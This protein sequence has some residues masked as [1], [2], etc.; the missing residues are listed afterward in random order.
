[1]EAVIESLGRSVKIPTGLQPSPSATSLRVGERSLVVADGPF[2]ETKEQI[3][4]AFVGAAHIS[5]PA[6]DR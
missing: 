6:S 3:L 2:A 4:G 1:M 5:S